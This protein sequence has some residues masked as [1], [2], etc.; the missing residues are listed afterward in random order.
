MDWLELSSYLI[1][2]KI[3]IIIIGVSITI[4]E[5]VSY[6]RRNKNERF[7]K[8]RKPLVIGL[9]MFLLIISVFHEVTTA[10]AQKTANKI[11][12]TRRDKV[13]KNDSLRVARII[14]D[15]GTAIG[16]IDSSTQNLVKVDSSIGVVKGVVKQQVN[17]L[18]SVVNESKEVQNNITGGD[19]YIKFYLI[20]LW[21]TQILELRCAV[22]GKYPMNNINL[23]INTFS[24]RDSLLNEQIKFEP[25]I[26][27]SGIYQHF[28]VNIPSFSSNN[29]TLI[30]AK[31]KVEDFKKDILLRIS[32]YST[33]GETFQVINWKNHKQYVSSSPKTNKITL[34][35]DNWSG[36]DFEYK[37]SISRVKLLGSTIISDRE[38]DVNAGIYYYENNDVQLKLYDDLLVLIGG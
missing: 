4:L 9:S 13:I 3:F 14:N 32:A 36:K 25:L 27:G 6:K 8:L 24:F 7:Q 22:I 10:E 37:T 17:K 19:S 38:L 16:K 33:N 20:K 34:T 15:L 30:I 5:V 12:E 1:W 23:K 18:T 35:N 2:F 29:S 11:E 26:Y 28:E 21:R 31:F